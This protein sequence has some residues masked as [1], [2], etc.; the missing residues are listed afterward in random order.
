MKMQ[1]L[2]KSAQTCLPS[3]FAMGTEAE[4]RWVFLLVFGLWEREGYVRYG[5]TR[6][7]RAQQEREALEGSAG[8]GR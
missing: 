7:E 6:A 3:V 1:R 5:N 8:R 2:A 4:K